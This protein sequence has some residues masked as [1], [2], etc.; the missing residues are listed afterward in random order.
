MKVIDQVFQDSIVE[1]ARAHNAYLLEKEKNDA[2]VA[3]SFTVCTYI[4][5]DLMFD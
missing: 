1:A 2:T 5:L 3:K 4:I